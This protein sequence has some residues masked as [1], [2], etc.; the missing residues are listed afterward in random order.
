MARAFRR[1]QPLTREARKLNSL[2]DPASPPNLPPPNAAGASTHSFTLELLLGRP[3][4]REFRRE[5]RGVLRA[6][7]GLGHH[8]GDGVAPGLIMGGFLVLSGSVRVAVNLDQDEPGRL[9]E[10]LDDVEPGD[11]RFLDARA[12]VGEGGRAKRLDALGL[13]LDLDVDD[14]HG[15]RGAGRGGPAV[16]GVRFNSMVA[17]AAGAA[18][19]GREIVRIG[20][21]AQLEGL[22]DVLADRFLDFM[23][24]T[25]RFEEAA[26]D[27][28][29]RERL[30]FL[31]EGGDFVVR[32]RQAVLLL[33]AQ[34][35]ALGDHRLEVR[36][37][38]FVS[39]EGVDLLAHRLEFRLFQDGLAEF[40][41][42]LHNHAFFGHRCHK[43]IGSIGLAPGPAK[44]RRSAGADCHQPYPSS[45]Q[46]QLRVFR[47]ALAR[48]R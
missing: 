15:A 1:Q 4:S 16:T 24:F 34:R 42:L 43:C 47:R 13:D 21:A 18:R 28:V 3:L 36:P 19:A 46:R 38:L 5:H 41:G 8:G 31:L 10:L 22:G 26:G 20:H 40:L 9:I 48:R 27:R 11:A 23:Q 44:G 17:T 12:G 35:L 29:G 39:H 7:A 2:G 30:A 45:K 33:L 32:H 37:G 6:G 25:L 14:E